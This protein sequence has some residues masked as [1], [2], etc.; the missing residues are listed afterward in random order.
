MYPASPEHLFSVSACQ[1]LIG[2]T[3]YIERY[4]W[5]KIKYHGGRNPAFPLRGNLVRA[6][7]VDL[8]VSL[9]PGIMAYTSNLQSR[10][11]LLELGG[12]TVCLAYASDRLLLS[13]YTRLCTI[14]DLPR[15]YYSTSPMLGHLDG[16]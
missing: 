2:P 6:L 9:E 10:S 16:L 11:L 15:R 1:Y 7:Y 14:V 3:C 4:C 13:D 12:C 5:L 8:L